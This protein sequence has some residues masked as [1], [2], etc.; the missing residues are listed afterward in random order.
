LPICF[1]VFS[2]LAI[3]SPFQENVHPLTSATRDTLADALSSEFRC[4]ECS[5]CRDRGVNRRHTKNS[6]VS[7]STIIIP[8]WMTPCKALTCGRMTDQIKDFYEPLPHNLTVKRFMYSDRSRMSG[9]TP[10]GLA[11]RVLQSLDVCHSVSAKAVSTKS[12]VD[13]SLSVALIA[14][15]GLILTDLWIFTRL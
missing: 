1:D 14:I 12:P 2:L 3:H 6:H 15:A 13:H 11:Y 5:D 7:A 4:Y 9:P 8:F 10:V